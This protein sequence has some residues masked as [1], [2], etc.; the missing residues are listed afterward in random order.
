MGCCKQSCCCITPKMSIVVIGLLVSLIEITLASCY[1]FHAFGCSMAVVGLIASVAFCCYVKKSSQNDDDRE[2]D[3]VETSV[4]DSQKYTPVPNVEQL[5]ANS[6]KK[7]QSCFVT[8]LWM[9]FVTLVIVVGL[10]GF[11]R[12]FALCRRM[13]WRNDLGDRYPTACGDWAESDGCTRIALPK[14]ECTRSDK[15]PSENSIVFT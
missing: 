3:S 15:I 7:K 13:E 2:R 11:T 14:D 4:N 8:A 10:L 12:L 6:K 5:I 9:L 1:N